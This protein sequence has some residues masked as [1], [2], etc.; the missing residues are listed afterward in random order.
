MITAKTM[1]METSKGAE[2]DAI[3]RIVSGKILILFTN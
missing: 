1:K 3:P 2:F